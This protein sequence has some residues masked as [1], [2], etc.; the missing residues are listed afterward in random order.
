MNRVNEYGAS[1][2]IKKRRFRTW[3]LLNFTIF[4]SDNPNALEEA[5]LLRETKGFATA[6]NIPRQP[7]GLPLEGLLT[8]IWTYLSHL[9]KF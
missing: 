7:S 3:V 8:Q 2:R 5:R 9:I 1:R 4:V 6:C